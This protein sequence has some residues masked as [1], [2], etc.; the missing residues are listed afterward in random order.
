MAH[1]QVLLPS[2]DATW[3]VLLPLRALLLEQCAPD[4]EPTASTHV[5]IT[6]AII[7]TLAALAARAGSLALAFQL[8]GSTAGVMVCFVLPGALHYSALRKERG[9]PTS[10]GLLALPQTAGEAAAIGM[11]IAGL[12]SGVAALWAT[13]ASAAR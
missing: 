8:G 12:L 10:E 13:L 4:S 9:A 6:A 3:Q 5:L 11:V 2:L 1:V 7:T